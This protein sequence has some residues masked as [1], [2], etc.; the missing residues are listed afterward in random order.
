MTTDPHY[1]SR[2]LVS[3][4]RGVLQ[5]AQTGSAVGLSLDGQ[6]WQIQVRADCPSTLWATQRARATRAY[7]RFGAWTPGRGLTAVPLNPILNTRDMI[8]SAQA[9]AAQLE[10]LQARL[11]FPQHDQRELW[12]VQNGTRRPLAL[13]ATAV[14]NDPLRMPDKPWW[15]AG[16]A[17]ATFHDSAGAGTADARMEAAMGEA[18]G[19]PA[20][21]LWFLRDEPGQG[22]GIEIGADT[23]TVPRQLPPGAFPELPWCERWPRSEQRR[24]ALGYS[25]RRAAGLLGLQQLPSTRRR[26]LELAA[27]KFPLQVAALWRIYPCIVNPSI[28]ISARVEARMRR[29]GR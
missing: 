4:W 17:P 22:P 10:A 1:Y 25:R 21:A 3:P 7:F 5:V 27:R 13:L 8:Q 29:A 12:L 11:P 28:L 2:R 9:L 16:D 24:L 14:D 20:E 18:A 26:R 23:G 6:H 15:N 19:E